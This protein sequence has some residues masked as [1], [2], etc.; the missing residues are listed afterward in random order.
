[1]VKKYQCDYCGTR[2]AYTPE[3]WRRH[4]R[5]A[6]HVAARAEHYRQVA[7][8]GEQLRSELGRRPCWRLSEPGGCPFGADCT[9]SH[10]SAAELE[11]LRAE[12]EAEQRPPPPPR[13]ADWLRSRPRLAEEP[14]EG[15]SLQWRPPPAVRQVTQVAPS[16]R[17]LEV[18]VAAH[19]LPEWG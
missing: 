14:S 16:L 15:V 5:G 10:L 4:V 19:L 2:F 9:F 3:T 17:P 18:T 8:A 11:R 13:L 12:A 6:A 1:M 7:P